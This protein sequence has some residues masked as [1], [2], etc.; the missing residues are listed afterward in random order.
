MS[1]DGQDRVLLDTRLNNEFVPHLP[2]LLKSKNAD[3]DAKKN[4]SRAFAGLAVAMLT[5]ATPQLAAASVTDDWGDHG[6]DAVHYDGATG[7]LFFIQVKLKE[8]D[9]FKQDE[10]QAFSE[11]VRKIILNDFSGF[12][13]HISKRQAA[14]EAD[15]EA[16]LAIKLVVA[17][18]GGGI[19]G[20]AKA[21]IDLMISQ[22]RDGEVRLDPEFLHLDAKAC[23]SFLQKGHAFAA[24]DDKL[25][26][27]SW[28]LRNGVRKSGVGFAA[29]HGLVNLHNAHGVALFSR[30]IRNALGTKRSDVNRAIIDT[31]RD[32]PADFEFLNNGV[33]II[34]DE[35]AP[36]GLR[37]GVRSVKLK[38]MSVINGAQTVSSAAAFM[39]DNPAHDISNAYV[40]VTVIQSDGVKEFGDAVTHARNH[41][42]VVVASN[43]VA[44]DEQQERLRRELAELGYRYVYKAGE[45]TSFLDPLQIDIREAAQALALTLPDPRVVVMLK[46]QPGELLT[47]GSDTYKLVFGS[48]TKAL[49][50]LNA[51]ITSRHLQLGMSVNVVSTAG[52]ERLTYKHGSY[53][54]SFVMMKCLHD[55]LRTNVRIDEAKMQVALSKPMDD[56]R[57]TLWDVVQPMTLYKGPLA[58]MRNQTDVPKVLDDIMTKHFDLAADVNL[59]KKRDKATTPA[60]I[61]SLFKYLAEK[62]PQIGGLS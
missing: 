16:C 30:N 49:S 60:G 5:E 6:I 48:K 43:F 46:R 9:Q 37:A 58:I 55:A 21:A 28:V 53:A 19:T 23:L 34:A 57:Q 33:T 18:V 13:A 39:K 17:E 42:N 22:E 38:G 7:V 12:N 44:L 45:D 56:L 10:A 24:V 50:L 11:G 8:A 35:V 62:A 20:T 40:Q 32:K 41:Q 47:V 36:A 14:I 27:H 59:P 61:Q 29:V 51:V 4:M 3:E 52:S 1:L 26:L 25:G 2:P 31:L 54:Y 15:L